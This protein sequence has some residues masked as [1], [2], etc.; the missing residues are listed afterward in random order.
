MSEV[1]TGENSLN[2]SKLT[3]QEEKKEWVNPNIYAIKAMK[4]FCNGECDKCEMV[5]EEWIEDQKRNSR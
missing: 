4:F 3:G 2:E 5:D 1:I